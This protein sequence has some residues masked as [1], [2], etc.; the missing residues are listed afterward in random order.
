V[1]SE[2][3]R[4]CIEEMLR[5]GATWGQIEKRCGVSRSTISRVRREIF[6]LEQ[7][8]KSGEGRSVLEDV[9]LTVKAIQL[10]EEGKALDPADLV[11][12][13][14]IP[15]PQAEELFNAIARTKSMTILPVSEAAEKLKEVVE[16]IIAAK[17]DLKFTADLARQTREELIKAIAE[18]GAARSELDKF[19]RSPQMIELRHVVERLQRVNLNE[20]KEAADNLLRLTNLAKLYTSDL[21][22]AGIIRAAT[23]RHRA[24]TR[25]SNGAVVAALAEYTEKSSTAERLSEGL[26]VTKH[27]LVCALCPFYEPKAREE[28]AKELKKMMK[29]VV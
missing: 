12:H 7:K 20:V 22:I 19:V 24:G 18:A 13:L 6:G 16:R 17:E 25:C 27:P 23:C 15:L 3:K 10:I 14:R 8:E 5:S 29:G 1:V 9:E 28:I 21:Y 26:D 2:E 4:R 11:K